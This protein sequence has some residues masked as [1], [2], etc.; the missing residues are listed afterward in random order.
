M[1]QFN[2]LSAIEHLTKGEED[3]LESNFFSQLDVEIANLALEHM[4]DAIGH[5]DRLIL[6]I[7]FALCHKNTREGHTCLHLNQ[8]VSGL[9]SLAGYWPSPMVWNE[10]ANK[11]ASYFKPNLNHTLMVWENPNRIYLRRFFDLEVGLAK[12]L[13]TFFSR[14]IRQMETSA[15]RPEGISGEQHAA[16]AATRHNALILLVGGPGTG[17]TY[18]VVHCIKDILE[19]QPDPSIMLAAPTGKAVARLT[20]SIAKALG[21][22]EVDQS[23]LDRFPREAFTLHRLLDKLNPGV[24]NSALNLRYPPDSVDWLIIDEASM[25]DLELMHRTLTSIPSECKLVLVG[26]VH[27]LASVEPGSILSDIYGGIQ[28]V[29]NDNQSVATVELTKN[30]RFDDNSRLGQLSKAVREGDLST[31]QKLLKNADSSP[32]LHWIDLNGV[33]R[34]SFIFENWVVDKVFPVLAKEDPEQVINEL[35]AFM[36]LSATN[37]GRYGVERINRRI[38]S[39]VLSECKKHGIGSFWS[40]VMVLQNDYGLR[41]F[42]GDIGLQRTSAVASVFSNAENSEIVYFKIEDKL[43]SFRTSRLPHNRSAFCISI[44][45]SQGS[46][47]RNVLLILPESRTQ[48]LSRELLYTAVSRAK[49]TLTIFSDMDAINKCVTAKT[50]RHGNLM[51]RIG[52]PAK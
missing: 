19:N 21:S 9:G 33:E 38:E 50:H 6:G 7:A 8:P 31:T 29:E 3:A 25:V 4:P 44:H 41:L 43:R 49:S 32:E 10:M 16:I 5:D 23:L 35:E 17:K 42:N 15:I 48:L 12:S 1:T 24:A 34:S 51:L 22:L 37:H 14:D 28:S 45:K 26:D 11:Y 36:V 47:A 20:Q 2:L 18:T 13:S 30:F 46:E 39:I 40:P 27:Q 52:D